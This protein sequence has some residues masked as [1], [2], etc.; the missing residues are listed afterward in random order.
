V[1]EVR[2]FATCGTLSKMGN[3]QKAQGALRTIGEV[4]KEVGVSTH[5]LRFWENNFLQIKP[6]KRRGRR[7]YSADDIEKIKAVKTLRYE[8][9]YTINGVNKRLK[10][11]RNT[12]DIISQPA[13]NNDEIT[14]SVS[15]Q[16]T[17]P[18]QT[19]DTSGAAAIAFGATELEKLREIYSGLCK[20]R[21]KLYASY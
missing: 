1:G 14:P 11:T 20:T 13:A 5:V 15:A 19:I 3:S 9:G 4:A 16:T 21:N 8:Q 6:Q 17:A 7:Y 2:L 10:Q 12:A 18:T